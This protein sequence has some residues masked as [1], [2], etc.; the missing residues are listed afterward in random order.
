[1]IVEE[2]GRHEKNVL[3]EVLRENVI[4]SLN[5]KMKDIHIISKPI[6]LTST[7][8]LPEEQEPSEN[9]VQALIDGC[10]PAEYNDVVKIILNLVESWGNRLR[11]YF[12]VP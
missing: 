5:K 2:F 1:L 9:E 10:S 4:R 8:W 7:V 3:G 11:N 6:S 12:R